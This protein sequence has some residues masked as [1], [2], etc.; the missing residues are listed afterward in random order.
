[1]SASQSQDET[2]SAK[3]NTN[4]HNWMKFFRAFWWCVLLSVCLLLILSRF[5]KLS[6]GQPA[7]FDAGLLIF[8]A[9]LILLPFVSEVSA[10]GIT[11]KRQIEEVKKELKQN[12]KDETQILRNDIVA[13][14][15]SN[16]LTSNVLVQ[17]G[18]PNPPPDS[19][20]NIIKEQIAEM[21]RDIQQQRGINEL[22]FR[23]NTASDIAFQQRYQVEKELKRIWS[24]RVKNGDFA[25]YPPFSR[26]VDELAQYELITYSFGKLLKDVYAVAS[27][28]VHG[29]EPSQEK[30]NFLREVAPEIIGTLNSIR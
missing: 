27:T 4:T 10:F 21:V 20:L 22:S 6:S 26:M 19:D 9:I 25:R 16:R 15:I 24:T 12:I 11:V 14:G 1:M 13:L 18:L 7:S 30:V 28:A 29:D 17:A 23:E 8:F 2:V 5:D 3:P